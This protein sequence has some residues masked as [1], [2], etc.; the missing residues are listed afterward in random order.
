[1]V[2]PARIAELQKYYQRAGGSPYIHLKGELEFKS[3]RRLIVVLVVILNT[4]VTA[5]CVQ[6]RLTG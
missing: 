4:Y 5:V 1:M 6:A 2:D 3:F